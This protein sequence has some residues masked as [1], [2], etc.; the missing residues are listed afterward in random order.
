MTCF[1]N[2]EIFSLFWNVDIS[3][4]DAAPSALEF[5]HNFKHNFEWLPFLNYMIRV[6]TSDLTKSSYYI[7]VYKNNMTSQVFR[8][9]IF[10]IC[11]C[12]AKFQLARAVQVQF[13]TKI[14]LIIT[15]NPHPP[16]HSTHPSIFEPLKDFLVSW[17]L[18]WRPEMSD[19]FH[20]RSLSV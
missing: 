9:Y 8:C 14:S 20:Y 3:T 2:F 7:I 4:F 1:S 5:S 12:Q 13:Q 19:S 15:V 10:C 17:N 11:N 6:W 16:T 18:T